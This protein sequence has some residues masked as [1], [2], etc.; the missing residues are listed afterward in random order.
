MAVIW[1]A[2]VALKEETLLLPDAVE[3]VNVM[4][5]SVGGFNEQISTGPVAGDV[6]PDPAVGRLHQSADFEQS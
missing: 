1:V 2:D 3:F 6:K 5:D 4:S